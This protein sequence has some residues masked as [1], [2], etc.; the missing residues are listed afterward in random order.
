MPARFVTIDRLTPMLLPPDL[1]DWI[2]HDDL[3]L[4]I[5]DAVDTLHLA[6]FRVNHRGTGSEQ[7]PPAM[8]LALLTYCYATGRFGSRTI[9]RATYSD[10]S[11]RYLCANTHPD[12]ETICEFRRQNRALFEETFVKILLLAQE[13][14]LLQLG[15]VSVDGSKFA[16]NASK[17]AAVSYARAGEL[18]EQ[19]QGEVRELLAKAEAADAVPLQDG[20]TIPAEITRREARQA[21]LQHARQVIE[22]RA[23]ERAAAAQPAY[24][25]K[26]AAREAK[27]RAGQRP[28]GRDP[29]PP[30]PT[31][32]PRDQ[33]NFTD[34]ASRIMKAGTGAHY[35]QAYNAQAVVDAD[36]SQLIV[37]QRLS[38]APND[39]QELAADVASVPEALGRPSAVLADSGFYSEAQV[40]AVEGAEGPVAYVAVEKTSHHRSVADLEQRPP[41]APPD[42]AASPR[43]QMRDRLRTAAGRAL[44]GLRKQTVEPVFG[45]IKSVLRFR[46]FQLRG[47]ANV[48][49]EWVLVCLAHNCK[50]L[51]VLWRQRSGSL[52]PV[53][54]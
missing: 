17:H 51:A 16:A 21:A 7:F 41:P 12:H 8:L 5:A 42:P 38:V 27:R 3:V 33:Y 14:G 32:Q 9:E 13:V 28:R 54:T 47:E 10:V 1:R 6:A 45:I 35:E 34:P 11:V 30:D 44:Y 46:Q 22:E 40:R 50:R 19:L 49:T 23:R 4:F 26:C 39:K 52:A 29:Q 25:A 2:Q 15:T 48:G 31:P 53:R 20:L 18:I 24:E 36:G 43:E 37:G